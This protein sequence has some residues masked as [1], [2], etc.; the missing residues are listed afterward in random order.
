MEKFQLNKEDLIG[1]L[2]EKLLL[3]QYNYFSIFLFFL[4]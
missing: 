2:L 1:D 4:T 3:Y